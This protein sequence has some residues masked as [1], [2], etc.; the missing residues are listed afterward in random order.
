MRS[1]TRA[2]GAAVVIAALGISVPALL[3]A[4]AGEKLKQVSPEF[5]CMVN[6]KHFA[7]EQT[8]VSIE[9]RNYYACCDPC[10]K[11]LKENAD[12]RKDV[13]PV[14]GKT[15]DKAKAA[16]GVDKQGNIYFFENTD[17]LRKFRVPEKS[18]KSPG[19]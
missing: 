8:L 6:K 2:L 16:I 7:K 1:S 9:G 14:S 5:V 11:Q 18:A 10:V 15:V 4:A 19:L 12:S 3:A 13:D 17:N